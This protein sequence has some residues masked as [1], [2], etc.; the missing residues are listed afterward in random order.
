M[1]NSVADVR[2]AAYLKTLKLPVVSRQYK[3]VAQ[4]AE[5]AGRSYVDFL[6]A[7]LE[8]EILQREQNGVQLRIQQARFPYPKTLDTFDF[9]ALPS[10]NKAKVMALT[11]CEWVSQR[12]NVLLVG[13]AGTGKT[14]LTIA[15]GAAACRAGKRVRYY[16]AASLVNELIAAHQDKLVPLIEGSSMGVVVAI[17]RMQCEAIL[18]AST[19]TSKS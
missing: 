2:L 15:L 13:N 5:A 18:Y 17:M 8:Q 10:L 16:T 11:H 1:S 3:S 12:E 19:R 7:L 9:V 6:A 4:E 14:H